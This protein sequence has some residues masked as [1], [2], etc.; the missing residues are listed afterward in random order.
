MRMLHW[1]YAA[2]ELKKRMDYHALNR[3][4]KDA[5]ATVIDE[6]IESARDGITTIFYSV[7]FEC[8]ES[9]PETCV[10]VEHV[11]DNSSESRAWY[12]R[13]SPNHPEIEKE[14]QK[15]QSCLSELADL[16]KYTPANY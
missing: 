1:F 8:T 5:D 7:P 10:L 13:D 3:P 15:V 14:F 11:I 16:Q 4:I 6:V 2:H 9:Y 12:W